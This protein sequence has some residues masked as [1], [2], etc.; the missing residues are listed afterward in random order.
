[1]E[2]LGDGISAEVARI[3]TAK[4]ERRQ[5]LARLPY[6]EKVRAIIQLQGMA[7]TILRARGKIVRPW[8]V[9]ATRSTPLVARDQR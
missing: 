4:Q 1:M 6:P 7:A 8:N 9:S 2:A 3:F 5:D